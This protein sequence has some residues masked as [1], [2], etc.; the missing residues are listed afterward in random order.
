[1]PLSPGCL[2]GPSARSLRPRSGRSWIESVMNE[3]LE[4]FRQELSEAVLTFIWQ[5]WSSVGVMAAGGADR[6]RLID[7]EPLLLLTLEVA[8]QDP[9]MFDVVVD[10]LIGNGK[11]II[12]VRVSTLLKHEKCVSPEVW[13]AL[14]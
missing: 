2:D 5:Q 4:K 14:A 11:A 9:R 8:R 7:P 10:W 13:G 12:G 6:T 3:S 1:M